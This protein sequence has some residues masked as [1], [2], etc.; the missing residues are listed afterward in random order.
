MNLAAI[1]GA[2]PSAQ[3]AHAGD[4]VLGV[5]RAVTQLRDDPRGLARAVG[6]RLTAT[7]GH[8]ADLRIRAIGRAVLMHREPSRADEI[9]ELGEL[10][11]HPPDSDPRTDR[12]IL[13]P[14]LTSGS[15]QTLPL[16]VQV[17]S[18]RFG[19]RSFA[20]VPIRGVNAVHGSMAIWRED[21]QPLDASSLD[22]LHACGE[23]VAIGLDYLRFDQEMRERVQLLE[24]CA[25]ATQDAMWS[26][27]LRHGTVRFSE[28]MASSFG[29]PSGEAVD[30]DWWAQR[31]HPADRARVVASLRHAV[32]RRAAENE[33]WSEQYRF[34]RAT[35]D[36]ADVLDCGLVATDASGAPV[37]M[38]GSMRAF[39]G[40][41]APARR[42]DDARCERLEWA[43]V[44]GYEMFARAA[45]ELTEPTRT[46]HVR[47]RYLEELLDLQE[48]SS[49]VTSALA[50][51]VR[52]A[53]RV[54]T[55]IESLGQIAKLPPD[56]IEPSPS[57]I[58]LV[59]LL[60]NLVRSIGC[61]ATQV[62]GVSQAI[63]RWDA[64]LVRRVLA[65]LLDRS[66]RDL[67]SGPGRVHIEQSPSVVELRFDCAGGEL[68]L[69]ETAR[70]F[71]RT[72][73]AA[74]QPHPAA[75]GFGWLAVQRVVLA[76]GGTLAVTTEGGRS[77][78]RLALPKR[79]HP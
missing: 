20:S 77:S 22:L 33:R 26:R 48:P 63:G 56:V 70:V 1:R 24:A 11:D 67:R 27:D 16:D 58:D 36:Y 43:S 12:S 19:M 50:R 14:R 49:E 47:L 74:G 6:S 44:L 66:C 5:A 15:M 30:H 42:R 34:L 55:M 76:L 40:V 46:L 73:H 75:S 18:R 10:L 60:R 59:Q 64:R 39:E 41:A 72:G 29:W 28:G 38:V 54:C 61:A 3:P 79:S 53:S 9:E 8:G 78:I 35:G 2:S 31:V 17:Y 21:D 25:R 32:G 52:E 62:T 45:T 65:N 4:V 23:Q 71:D 37:R 69:A 7:V 51:S 57:E 13:L 68:P